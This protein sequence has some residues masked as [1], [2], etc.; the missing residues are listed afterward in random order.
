MGD[1][2]SEKE[3]MDKKISKRKM[4]ERLKKTNIP[5]E[6]DSQ[7]QKMFFVIPTNDI[8][9]SWSI[10]DV[11]IKRC[12]YGWE[13]V[14]KKLGNTFD[15]IQK[16]IEKE[17]GKTV[18][19]RKDIFNAFHWCPL[20]KTKVVIFGQD[21]Y[22]TVNYD[23]IPDAVGVSFSTRRD[24]RMRE[25][26]Q[27]IFLEVKRDYPSFQIPNHG[28]LR[29][30][31]DQGV[32]LL[33]MSLTTVAGIDR[34]HGYIW[35]GVIHDVITEIKNYAPHSVIIMWGKDAQNQILPS[36]G[37]LK[38]LTASHPSPKSAKYGFFGCEHFKLTNEHLTSKGI[39]PIDWTNLE[40]F[41]AN[42]F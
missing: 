10:R 29:G 20:E 30:W 26:V 4:L 7:K 24:S 37:K 22:Y 36:V 1:T 32:L 3:K 41:S 8:T 35:S 12:P 16:V 27:N 39:K 13:R 19:L 25:S 15:H 18:P 21:P 14:F 33:N 2:I 38:Y 17:G 6:E 28:D 5:I 42:I 9:E 11:A 23:G 34:A 40:D 31:A